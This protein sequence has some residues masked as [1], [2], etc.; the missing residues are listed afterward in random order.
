MTARTKNTISKGLILLL[1]VA[2]G[3]AV[4]NLYY[5][6]PLLFSISK[7][8]HLS[9]AQASLL[10]TM[11][12]VGYAF[13]LLFV[14]PLGD[15]IQ[16]RKL[17]I[18]ILTIASVALLGTGL[19]KNFLE[20]ALASVIVGSASVITHILIPFAADLAPDDTQGKVVARVMSGLLSGILLA[21]TFSGIISQIFGWRT[22]YFLSAFFMIALGLVLRFSLPRDTKRNESSYFNLLNS[23]WKIFLQEKTLRVRSLL[24]ALTFFCFSALWTTLTFLLSKPPFRYQ[25]AEIGLFGLVG[26]VGIVAANFAGR[27]VDSNK[28][29]QNTVLSAVLLI[30]SFLLLYFSSMSVF[31][32]IAGIIALDAAVQTMQIT[33][34]G[35]IFRLNSKARSRINSAYMFCYFIGASSGSVIGGVV[36][37]LYGWHALSIGGCAIGILTLLIALLT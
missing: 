12:Q 9:T 15:K 20:F 4:A 22:V 37:Q 19:S 35:V 14:V 17:S 13:G 18:V 6:Q 1:A 33:S 30:L 28:F 21:R 5:L 10:V 7:E 8:L 27:N 32:V 25:N 2:T 3:L 31:I 29:K 34:Q 11:V 26:L 36:Y 23:T 16:R 24:G